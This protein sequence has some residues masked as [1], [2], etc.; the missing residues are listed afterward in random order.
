MGALF[1]LEGGEKMTIVWLGDD[2]EKVYGNNETLQK[3]K[4]RPGQ[5]ITL[6]FGTITIPKI[7]ELS[8][9]LANNEIAMSPKLT[10]QFSLPVDALYNVKAE[11][12]NVYLGPLVSLIVSKE[13]TSITTEKLELMKERLRNYQDIKGIFFVASQDLLNL[14]E[15][16]CKGYYYTCTGEWKKWHFPLPEVIINRSYFKKDVYNEL[17]SQIGSRVVSNC[18]MTKDKLWRLLKSTSVRK[19]LPYTCRLRSYESLLDVMKNFPSVYLKPTNLSRGNG[20][21]KMT[22][23]ENGIEIR[24]RK[25]ETF[26]VSSKEELQ[27]YL[28]SLIKK[29]KYLIQQDVSYKEPKGRIADFRVYVQKD[30]TKEWNCSGI[31]CRLSKP[32]SIVSNYKYTESILSFH[33]ASDKIFRFSELQEKE[34]ENIIIEITKRVCRQLEEKGQI[35]SDVAIDVAIDPSLKV[36]VLEVQVNYAVDERLYSLPEEMYKKVWTTPLEYAKALCQF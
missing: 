7:I 23:K 13:K 18:K 19:F 28:H 20:I 27:S 34:L 16:S 33:E 36:W 31:I 24:S 17:T 4:L 21:I 10:D 35:L 6:H 12:E 1:L 14:G 3:L 22:K 2:S 29:R 8:L 15:G 25:N 11:G 9:E 30:A 26:I 32:G 5:H